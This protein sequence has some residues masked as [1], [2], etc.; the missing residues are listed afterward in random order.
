MKRFS[1]LNFIENIHQYTDFFD[2]SFALPRLTVIHWRSV[3]LAEL[4]KCLVNFYGIGC[5][6][7][8]YAAD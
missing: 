1:I 7:A 6:E 4:K 3:A 2:F 8:S 5:S